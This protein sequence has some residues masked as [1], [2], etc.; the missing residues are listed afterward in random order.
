MFTVDVKGLRSVIERRGGKGHA[1]MEL[2]QNALDADDATEVEVFF[3]R[4]HGSRWVEVTVR[5]DSPKGFARLSD[6]YTM[7]RKSTKVGDVQKRGMFNLGEKLVIAMMSGGATVTS[8]TGQVVF[9]VANNERSETREKT[10]SGSVFQGKLTMT[11]DE[12][13]EAEAM[14][15]SILTPEGIKLSVNGELVP[16][17]E[18]K[19]TVE[20]KHLPC[21]LWDDESERLKE[22]KRNT[23]ISIVEVL[24]D[25]EPHLYVLGLPVMPLY[26]GQTY[27]YDVGH[28]VPTNLERTSVRKSVMIRVN[29]LCLDALADELDG[30]SAGATWV[31][32]AL[33][34]KEPL[35]EE[36]A[37]AY[38]EAKMG[39][40]LEK[41]AVFCPGDPEANDRAV[42]A[43][44]QL[45]RGGH[46]PSKVWGAV[47]ENSMVGQSSILTPSHRTQAGWGG[48]DVEV[49]PDRWTP[50]QTFVVEYATALGSQLLGVPVRTRIVNDTTAEGRKYLATYRRAGHVLTL[51]LR[52]LGRRWFKD[53]ANDPLAARCIETLVHEFAHEAVSNHL[54]DKFHDE[55]CALAAKLARLVFHDV[56]LFEGMIIDARE[57]AKI[58]AA[59]ESQKVSVS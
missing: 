18:A 21:V 47:R 14:L 25:E 51:N 23:T 24:P 28:R 8:T 39:A 34:D 44:Y 11:R 12:Q 3:D 45:L 2:V 59:P 37:K 13:E 15:R 52:Q 29:R 10:E 5:D 20:A 6:A 7:F 35:T 56:K 41:L 43:G 57:A 58:G 26:E 38:V 1:I 22:T 31:R 30:E 19:H 33:D 53:L 16:F 32:A 17:R 40:P 49:K 54:S 36:T 27:H 42:A 46:L 4:E 48:A 50:E 9:D 55:C